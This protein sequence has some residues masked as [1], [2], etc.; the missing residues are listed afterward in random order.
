MSSFPWGCYHR[1]LVCWALIMGVCLLTL[2]Y[3]YMRC[4][5]LDFYFGD[6]FMAYLLWLLGDSFSCCW[7]VMDCFMSCF[8][9]DVKLFALDVNPCFVN[10]MSCIWGISFVWLWNSNS[11]GTYSGLFDTAKELDKRRKN[12]WK[13]N[14]KSAHLINM[15]YGGFYLCLFS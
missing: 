3:V 8:A 5:R 6:V 12:W 2:Y 9:L 13:K 14:P 11:Y 4:L 10:F 15:K 7:N 1:V